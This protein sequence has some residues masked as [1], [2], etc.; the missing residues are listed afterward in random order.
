MGFCLVLF[1]RVLPNPFSRVFA[2]TRHPT[3]YPFQGVPKPHSLEQS[4]RRQ[5]TPTIKGRT[6]PL[7]ISFPEK[8]S[9]R[10]GWRTHKKSRSSSMNRGF[11]KGAYLLTKRGISKDLPVL[12]NP[13]LTLSCYHA[14]SHA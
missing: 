13:D 6:F 12:G 14:W 7:L 10:S 1:L 2:L 11:H 8:E 5:D 9:P 3:D 4:S